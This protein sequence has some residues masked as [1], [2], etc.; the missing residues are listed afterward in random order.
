VAKTQTKALWLG[1]QVTTTKTGQW[2]RRKLEILGSMVRPRLLTY[3]FA[4]REICRL[5]TYAG[6]NITGKGESLQ[7]A[8]SPAVFLINLG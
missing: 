3:I 2:K 6:V 1:N 8:M 4:A 7:E 5:Y